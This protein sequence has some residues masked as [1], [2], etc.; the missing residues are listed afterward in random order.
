MEW[1]EIMLDRWTN[2]HDESRSG[3]PFDVNDGWVNSIKGKTVHNKNALWW[4]TM[5]FK[6]CL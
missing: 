1:W 4:V 3:R 5:N 6:N 2:N